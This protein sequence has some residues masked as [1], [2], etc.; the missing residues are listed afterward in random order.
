[1]ELKSK[2][3]DPRDGTRLYPQPRVGK[4]KKRFY[5][6]LVVVALTIAAFMLY[7]SLKEALAAPLPTALTLAPGQIGAVE[8][9]WT[10]S[11]KILP[12]ADLFGEI[13]IFKGLDQVNL[14]GRDFFV[15]SLPQT[16]PV[17]P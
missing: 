5:I 7:M 11:K 12:D 8:Q 14:V 13:R 6:G 2:F 4:S 17:L 10:I 3:M 15:I 16:P 1:M 9:R